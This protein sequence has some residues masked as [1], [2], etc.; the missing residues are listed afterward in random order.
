MKHNLKKKYLWRYRGARFTAKRLGI[1]WDLMIESQMEKADIM[2]AKIEPLSFEYGLSSINHVIK[3]KSN[4]KSATV[5][6]KSHYEPSVRSTTDGESAL[7]E[8]AGT[9]SPVAYSC[10]SASTMT[11]GSL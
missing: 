7:N 1:A 10:F 6:I 4:T 11:L 9:T 3:S 2:S 5:G 8:D